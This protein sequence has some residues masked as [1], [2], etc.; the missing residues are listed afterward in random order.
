MPDTGRRLSPAIEL[1]AYR[2]VQEALTNVV[3][4][5]PQARVTVDV[6]VSQASLRVEIT[7]NG[8]SPDAHDGRGFAP[9][10][11]IAGMRER[12]SAF[13]GSLVAG[14]C[15]DGGFRVLAEIPVGTAL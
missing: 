3:K 1:T 12:I 15:P 5:A 11:G 14:P 4:H 8:T 13:G 7:D 2:V 10:H 6:A 9:G